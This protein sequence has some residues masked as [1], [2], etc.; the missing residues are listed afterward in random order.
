MPSIYVFLDIFGTL[1]LTNMNA[2]AA[3]VSRLTCLVV[4]SQH[5]MN[6]NTKDPE[7]YRSAMDIFTTKD[8]NWFATIFLKENKMH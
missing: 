6:E 5:S 7:H 2:F 1:N 4:L 8:L 3:L